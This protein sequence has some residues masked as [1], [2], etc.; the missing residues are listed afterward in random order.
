M[1]RAALAHPTGTR[2]DFICNPPSTSPSKPRA[3]SHDGLIRSW[4]NGSNP[5]RIKI[6]GIDQFSSHDCSPCLLFPS[7]EGRGA[8]GEVPILHLLASRYH[9][10]P[11]PF[12]SGKGN[13]ILR[14]RSLPPRMLDRQVVV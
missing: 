1:R 4:R 14:N 6:G 8:R 2:T 3:T 10:E 13:K 9:K 5:V 7:P 12:P 11:N